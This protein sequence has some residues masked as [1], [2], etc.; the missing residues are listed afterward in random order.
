MKFEPTIKQLEVLTFALYCRVGTLKK[1]LEGDTSDTNSLFVVSTKESLSIARALEKKF[2]A[3][4]SKQFK[5][6][7]KKRR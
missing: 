3:E 1:L 2:E 7:N 5:Q 6:C 4:L